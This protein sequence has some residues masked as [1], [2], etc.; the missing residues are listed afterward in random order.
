VHR[1]QK[2]EH[3]YLNNRRYQR[4]QSD[5]LEGKLNGESESIEGFKS[6]LRGEKQYRKYLSIFQKEVSTEGWE[7]VV[8]RYLFHGDELGDDLL[9][10]LFARKLHSSFSSREHCLLFI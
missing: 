9:E 5:G 3:Y 6:H 8:Q 10:T 1:P 7:L 2:I 4:T